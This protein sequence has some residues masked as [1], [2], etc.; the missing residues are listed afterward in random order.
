[1]IVRRWDSTPVCPVY[2][3]CDAPLTSCQEIN[4]LGHFL[5][6]DLR[7]DRD[8][9]CRCCLIQLTCGAAV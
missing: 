5:T 6:D 1:M 4:Y 7:D 2:K 9:Y 8:V 3:L